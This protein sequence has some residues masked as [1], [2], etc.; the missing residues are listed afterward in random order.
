MRCTLKVSR[1][2]AIPAKKKIIWVSSLILDIHLHKTSRIE[3]LRALAKR[4]HE[5]FLVAM[6]SSKKKDCEFTDVHVT[7]IPLRYVPFFS[8]AVYTLLLLLY[9]PLSFLQLRPDFVIVEPDAT[10]LSVTPALLFP[11]SKK[12]KI[13][14]DV[15]STPV[16]IYGIGGYL[17]TQ[18]FNIAINT[19]KKFF[20]GITIITPL[21]KKEVCENYGVNSKFVGVWTSG[22][23]TIAFNPENCSG[24]EM[25]KKF[26]LEGKFIILHHGVFGKER[27]IIETI[28]AFEILKNRYPDLVLFLL[29]R[30]DINLKDIIDELGLQNMVIVHDTVSYTEVR[31]YIAMCDV[32]IVPLPNLS[33]WRY[34]CPLNLLEYL[35][36]KKAVIATDI[37]ANREVLKESECGI[38]AS[39]A[40]P[41]A[42][43][44]AIAYTYNKRSKLRE[45]GTYGRALIE[46]RYTW[47]KVAEDL[48]SYLLEL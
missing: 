29:G 28:K 7:S 6:S 26:Q 2:Q 36:M 12:P 41:V 17:K 33:D 8:P 31:N 27:G 42:I 48:E 9:L 35:A 30:G 22:V 21:M 10:V 14:L 32:G 46:E 44:N 40:N 4:G 45:W 13:I 24:T 23:S 43:A 37:P 20:Q 16:G 3:I 19:A 15:R 39:S 5:V 34:Q 1:N 18:F 47:E 25:R 11:R 38:Y